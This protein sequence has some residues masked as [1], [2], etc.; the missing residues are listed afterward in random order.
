MFVHLFMRRLACWLIS[1]LIAGAALAASDLEAPF[2]LDDFRV[3]GTAWRYARAGDIEILSQIPPAVARAVLSSL[4]RGQRLVPGFV[5][6]GADLPLKLILVEGKQAKAGRPDPMKDAAADL[7]SWGDAY[8]VRQGGIVEMADDHAQVMAVNY[9]GNRPA[10]I[11]MY[12]TYRLL[13]AQRPPFPD[14]VVTGLF[15]ER[16]SLRSVLGV[17]RTTSIQFA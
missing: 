3:E 2:R 7:R 12:R 9:G 14:W 13:R 16:A 10:Q 15:G 1:W 11:L 6:E 17:P 5:I 8:V 4:L